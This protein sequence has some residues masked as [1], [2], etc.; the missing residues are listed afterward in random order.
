MLQSGS[1]LRV[2]LLPSQ[3]G[4]WQCLETFWLSQQEGG[5][6]GTLLASHSWGEARGAAETSTLHGQA[7]QHKRLSSPGG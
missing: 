2:I 7:P 5:G 4:L 6:A 1:Q 3:E